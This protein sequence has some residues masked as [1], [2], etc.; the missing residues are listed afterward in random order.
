MLAIQ[1]TADA[2]RRGIRGVAHHGQAPPRVTEGRDEAAKS[3]GVGVG[4]N[5]GFERQRLGGKRGGVRERDDDSRVRGELQRRGRGVGVRRRVKLHAIAN[6]KRKVVVQSRQIVR[7]V[8]CVRHC[9]VERVIREQ[10]L[11]H[12]VFRVQVRVARP[13]DLPIQQRH[14][15]QANVI[16]EPRER[17]ARDR[18]VGCQVRHVCARRVRPERERTPAAVAGGGAAS[19]AVSG[20]DAVDVKRNLLRRGIHGDGDVRP[21]VG[22][23]GEC[24]MRIHVTRRVRGERQDVCRIRARLPSG[25]VHVAALVRRAVARQHDAPAVIAEH[26]NRGRIR[27]R[28]VSL[29]PS[30]ERE[31][32]RT[33]T[34]GRAPGG[35]HKNRGRGVQDERRA[36]AERRRV[37]ERLGDVSREERHVRRLGNRQAQVARRRPRSGVKRKLRNDVLGEPETVI[38]RTVDEH[39]HGFG[40]DRRVPHA[41]GV[42]RTGKREADCAGAPAGAPDAERRVASGEGIAGEVERERRDRLAGGNAVDVESDERLIFVDAAAGCHGHR[43]VSPIASRHGG[44]GRREIVAGSGA[45]REETDRSVEVPGTTPKAVHRV[46]HQ[47]NAPPFETGAVR[48]DRSATVSGGNIGVHPRVEG[49]RRERRERGERVVAADVVSAAEP[50]EEQGTVSLFERPGFKL[51]VVRA[52]ACRGELVGRVRSRARVLCARRPRSQV[53][54]GVLPVGGLVQH[55][56]ALGRV[57]E[58]EL[59]NHRVQDRVERI[60]VFVVARLQ[61]ALRHG[62]VPQAHDVHVTVVPVTVRRTSSSAMLRAAELQRSVRS[63]GVEGIG[64]GIDATVQTRPHDV[65]VDEKVNSQGS[66]GIG[67]AHRDVAPLPSSDRFVRQRVVI[68]V[69]GGRIRRPLEECEVIRASQ[70]QGPAPVSHRREHL[71]GRL[72]S[73]D[74]GAYPRL[75]R[76]GTVSGHESDGRRVLLDDDGRV[77][78]ENE[79]ARRRDA[80]S[81]REHQTRIVDHDQNVDELHVVR[82]AVSDRGVWRERVAALHDSVTSH[83]MVGV[84]L[85]DGIL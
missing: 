65:P 82:P 35:A 71:D 34:L 25:D 4:I 1:A 29:D 37:P 22:D 10:R 76:H 67:R 41:N 79:R 23:H 13:R 2:I 27:V 83:E 40:G 60:R 26:R 39:G 81:S 78:V 19:G 55:D 70:D 14:V 68:N 85:R 33:Q 42:H 31:L 17:R 80:V 58:T 7:P 43:D 16:D 48:H 50:V 72:R 38:R 18:W 49:Q 74:I 59:E 32:F 11:H 69:P 46:A 51:D 24:G 77:S 57:V 3:R 63:A 53:H 28:R 8:V 6:G 52:R 36:F 15:P 47:L 21:R 56:V 66:S 75:E 64:R 20:G 12:R 62:V 54:D 30:F 44:V 9:G 61:V 45:F 84:L 73:H 5:P